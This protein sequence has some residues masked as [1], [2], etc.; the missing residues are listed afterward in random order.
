MNYSDLE[1]YRINCLFMTKSFLSS[2]IDEKMAELSLS[3]KE[4]TSKPT[5]APV[6]KKVDGSLIKSWVVFS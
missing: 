2:S 4:T 1:K 6:R 3:Q 5:E